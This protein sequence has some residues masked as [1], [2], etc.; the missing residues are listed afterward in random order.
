MRR[1]VWLVI[2]AMSVAGGAQAQSLAFDFDTDGDPTT[3]ESEITAEVGDIVEAYLV[4][5]DFLTPYPLLWGL[6]FGL[7]ATAGLQLIGLYDTQDSGGMMHDGSEGI[8]LA[9]SNPFD[10]NELPVFVARFLFRVMDPSEQTVKLAASTGWGTTQTG[11]VWAVSDYQGNV[12]EVT[13]ANTLATQQ[14]GRVQSSEQLPTI[15]S[16]WG[17]IKKLYQDD[18]I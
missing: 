6:M 18:T 16:S 3:I 15:E 4:V 5:E 13:D 8:A 7:D 9:Y 10:R 12:V 17:K 14:I 11:V 1:L 2:A